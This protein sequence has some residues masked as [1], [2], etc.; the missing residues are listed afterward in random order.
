M[1]TL[2]LTSVLFATVLIP[3]YAARDKSPQRGLRR[4]MLLFF[5][6]NAVYAFAIIYIWRR[7]L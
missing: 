7:L 6:F 4:T 2:L 3:M 5:A 1:A